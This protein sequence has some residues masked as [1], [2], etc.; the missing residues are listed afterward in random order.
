MSRLYFVDI[1]C[2]EL[3]SFL[4]GGGADSCVATSTRTRERASTSPWGLAGTQHGGEKDKPWKPRLWCWV[5]G[6]PSVMQFPC[7]LGFSCTPFISLVVLNYYLFPPDSGKAGTPRAWSPIMD[8]LPFSILCVI[9]WIQGCSDY[10]VKIA[11][12]VGKSA[13]PKAHVH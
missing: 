7:A 2:F 8:R 1:S 5:P 13:F 10:A 11:L 9:F 3:T 12:S 4:F 6:I